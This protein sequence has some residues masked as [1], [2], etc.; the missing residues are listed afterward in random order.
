MKEKKDIY[1]FKNIFIH[2]ISDLITSNVDSN[3]N[4]TY[5]KKK[6]GEIWGFVI[7]IIDFILAINYH[8]WKIKHI[9]LFFIILVISFIIAMIL[10]NRGM[11]ADKEQELN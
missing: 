3:F 10:I 8:I 9:N 5:C 1:N 6:Y 4:N 2:F 7:L 11:L